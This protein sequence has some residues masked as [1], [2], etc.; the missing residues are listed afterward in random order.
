M[1][2]KLCRIVTDLFEVNN[3]GYGG[4]RLVFRVGLVKLFVVSRGADSSEFLSAEG[5]GMVWRRVV[6]SLRRVWDGS[7]SAK[8]FR[9]F[10][11]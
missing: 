4:F 9:V 5:V 10:M 11:N 7:P 8:R 1:S 6:S 2:M 3:F